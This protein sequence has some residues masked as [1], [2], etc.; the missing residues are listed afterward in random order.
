MLAGDLDEALEQVVGIERAGRVVRVDDHDALG[1]RR[2]LGADVGQVR[3]PAVV[4]VAQVVHRRAAR[5]A[6]GSGPQRVVGGRQQ[7]LVAV[8]EQRV[9]GHGD[10]LAG[11]VAQVDVVERDARDA[12]LLGLVHHGLARRENALAVR[13]ARRGRQVADHVLLDLLRRIEAEHGQVAD[14]ELDDLLA[15]F[16]HLL[17]GVHDGTADV[18]EDVGQLG[19]FLELLQRGPPGRVYSKV[20]GPCGPRVTRENL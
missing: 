8:V 12:L 7:Q 3:H 17:G 16:L 13:V 2:D 4:L 19:R 14:V 10:Q 5:Q 11:A 1:A 20:K 18:I 9:G 6:C 15:F